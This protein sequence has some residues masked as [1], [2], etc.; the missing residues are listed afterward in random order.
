MLYTHT[1]PLD[2][3]ESSCIAAHSIHPKSPS[4]TLVD[5][6]SQQHARCRERRALTD[7]TLPLGAALPEMTILKYGGYFPQGTAFPGGVL[8]PMHARM[9]NVLPE[10][11][12]APSAAAPSES[13]C[14]VQ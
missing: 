4:E 2:P 10:E 14:L 12:S 1:G 5:V 8:V 3:Y 9:V 11:T 7:S 6:S 13:L